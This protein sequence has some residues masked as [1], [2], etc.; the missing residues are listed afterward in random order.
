M[1]ATKVEKYIA[2]EAAKAFGGEAK[3]VSPVR[4][5]ETGTKHIPPCDVFEREAGAVTKS[6]ETA[7]S[8][9]EIRDVDFDTAQKNFV[10]YVKS[11]EPDLSP[12]E[13]AA[14]KKRVIAGINR[15]IDEKISH[16]EAKV[17]FGNFAPDGS[18]ATRFEYLKACAKQKGYDLVVERTAGDD[19]S[20]YLKRIAKPVEAATGKVASEVVKELSELDK[21]GI[22]VLNTIDKPLEQ[23]MYSGGKNFEQLWQEEL[24][25][26][27]KDLNTSIDMDLECALK[28]NLTLIPSGD[29]K[30]NRY[31]FLHID[32]NH[33]SIDTYIQYADA[34][35]RL[36]NYKIT[37]IM[38]NS[39]WGGVHFNLEKI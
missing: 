13:F 37:D 33:P 11:I 8:K 29:T 38:K 17:L 4:L 18:M 28:K 5:T 23:S 2:P 36:M 31:G 6:A 14:K 12:A 25:A 24:P 20:V 39:H 22:K 19:V 9:M 3:Y 35:A 15:N 16:N 32:P 26:R 7:A 34:R 30:Y 1:V 27:L 21:Q 10:E